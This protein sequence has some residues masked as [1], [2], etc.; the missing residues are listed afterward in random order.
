MIVFAYVL[1]HPFACIFSTD[2]QT[3][4]EVRVFSSKIT[5]RGLLPVAVADIVVPV[6]L[7]TL[8]DVVITGQYL[9]P[10][11]HRKRSLHGDGISQ[12][13]DCSHSDEALAKTGTLLRRVFTK[14][15]SG[16]RS[17]CQISRSCLALGLYSFLFAEGYVCQTATLIGLNAAC[18]GR[19]NAGIRVCCCVKGDRRCTRRDCR[20]IFQRSRETIAQRCER[21]IVLDARTEEEIR[22]QCRRVQV[23]L[24]HVCR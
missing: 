17:R 12:K 24:G 21:P 5:V 2:T 7:Q 4:G 16:N 8:P 22:R 18:W 1:P 15:T 6:W 9:R 14:S 13:A 23:I 3:V 11:Q 10:S 20:R 19:R